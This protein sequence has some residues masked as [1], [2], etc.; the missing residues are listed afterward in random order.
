MALDDTWFTEIHQ[1]DGSAFSLKIKAKL[2]DEQT[3]FQRIEIFETARWGKLIKD[4]GLKL[5]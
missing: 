3:P 1:A 4:I 2:H 5:E